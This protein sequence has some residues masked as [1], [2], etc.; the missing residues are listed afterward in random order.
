M[1]IFLSA[2][3]TTVGRITPKIDVTKRAILE[4][5]TSKYLEKSAN[6]VTLIKST[7]HTALEIPTFRNPI[8]I[9]KTPYDGVY[10][11]MRDYVSVDRMTAQ[12]RVRSPVDF[13]FNEMRANLENILRTEGMGVLRSVGPLPMSAFSSLISENIGRNYGLNP[14]H[15][16]VLTILAAYYFYSLTTNDDSPNEMELQKIAGQIAK[17]TRASVDKVFEVLDNR[18]FIKNLDE[19]VRT[20]KEE[21]GE[22]VN[23]L[24]NKTFITGLSSITWV[25]NANE[26][27]AI[28]L[29][30]IPTLFS[31][32]Y[33]VIKENSYRRCTLAQVVER[34]PMKGTADDFVR[35]LS[36]MVKN[37]Q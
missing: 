15:Q 2:Y 12:E 1:S 36:A 34:C 30:H 21:F 28:G 18:P 10:V 33:V 24:N 31:M 19:F 16:Y 11:D 32:I 25:A 37:R 3:D 27:N 8:Y 6:G 13:A 26:V 17:A 20:V 9:D 23:L 14:E 29:E 5:L 35:T 7:A 22:Q 4:A